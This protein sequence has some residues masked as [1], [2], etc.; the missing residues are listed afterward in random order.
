VRGY[1]RELRQRSYGVVEL[2]RD[3]EHFPTNPMG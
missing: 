1:P 2:G 3:S